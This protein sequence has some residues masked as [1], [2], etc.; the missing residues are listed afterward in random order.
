MAVKTKAAISAEINSTI[1]SG[2]AITATDLN[3]ILI[4]IVDSYEDLI[5]E[6]TTVDRDL[7]TPFEGLKIY[8]T[9]SNRLEYYSASQWMPCSQK[10]V[11]ALDCSA[12]P[13]YSE[14]LVGDQYI[15]SVAGLIGGAS[16]KSVYVGDLVYCIEDNAGGNEAT[17]GTKWMV[18]HSASNSDSPTFY[19]ELVITS[20]E[21]LALGSTPIEIVPACAAGKINLVQQVVCSMIY[22]S[23]PYATATNMYLEW[24]DLNNDFIIFDLSQANNWH[25]IKPFTIQHDSY[26]LSAL[27]VGTATVNPTAG[28]SDVKVGIYYKIHTM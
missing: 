26:S 1:V 7:L 19:A 15:V 4:D 24:D 13:N 18:C 25:V 17:V 6:Y 21:I 2:G 5:V 28:D 11:V 20:A 27:K 8:N 16:G 23:T 10:E 3:G 22:N 12:N 14:A 9:T